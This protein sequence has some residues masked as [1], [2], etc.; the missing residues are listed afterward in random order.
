[1]RVPVTVIPVLVLIASTA[2]AQR[3]ENPIVWHKWDTMTFRTNRTDPATLDVQTKGA[4]SAVRLDFASGGSLIFLSAGPDRWTASIPAARLLDGYRLDNV[5]HNFVGF[6]LVLGSS[7]ETLITYNAFIQVFD[8]LVP[9]AAIRE[10]GSNA[11]ATERIANLYRPGI[12]VDPEGAARQFYGYFQDDYDFVQVLYTIP[13]YS[14]TPLT[15]HSPVRNDVA[16][17]GSSIFNYTAGFGS[18]GRLQGITTFPV[19]E[20]FDGAEKT[21][22]HE[23][24]HQWVNHLLN[25]ILQPGAHWPPST[26][27]RGIMGTNSGDF[28]Y[29][30]TAVTSTTA[31]LTAASPTMEFSDFDLYLMGLIPPAAVAP[32]IVVQGTLCNGCVVPSVSV[33]VN[34]VIAVNGARVPDWNAAQRVFRV[35]TIVVTRDRLLN[36]DEMAM[37]EYFAGRGE[38]TTPLPYSVGFV[39]GTT[40]PFFVATHGLGRVDLRLVH[41]PRRRSVR[42]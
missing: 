21:F 22:S 11:R 41:T 36:D 20:Y 24:G 33:T 37:F 16:G 10:L 39:R 7:G 31:K 4:V 1:V 26:M 27:A 6:L 34:D 17:I 18:A 8:S 9:V 28:P 15:Y 19:A 25:S 12:G 5:N 30:V 35:A 23:L 3:L 2:F 13:S 32:G 14:G 29:D 42:R 38:G 40:K